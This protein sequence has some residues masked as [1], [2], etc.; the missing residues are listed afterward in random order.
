MLIILGNCITLALYRPKEPGD[1]KWNNGLNTA[2]IV[3]N[4]FFS[5]E[6]VLRVLAAGSIKTYLRNRWNLFD[7]TM[8]AFGWTVLVPQSSGSSESSE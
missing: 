8:V 7:L 4:S 2:D 1:G 6:L 3:F 5:L